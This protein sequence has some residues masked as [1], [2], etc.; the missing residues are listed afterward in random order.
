MTELN[1]VGIINTDKFYMYYCYDSPFFDVLRK[2]I[3]YSR[4]CRYGIDNNTINQFKCSLHHYEIMK[5]SYALGYNR[6]LILE[7]DIVFL[8]DL[9]LYQKILQYIPTTDLVLFDKFIC[10]YDE[11]NNHL[12][13]DQKINDYYMSFN[14]VSLLSSACYSVNRNAM[15]HITLSQEKEFE[16]CDH[17]WNLNNEYISKITKS[18]SI[19]NL[20]IQKN[21]TDHNCQ[22]FNEKL[23]YKFAHVNI[24]DYI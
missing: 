15:K 11:F 10:S 13:C 8:K 22:S 1:R 5:M 16:A 23:A 3:S 18:Y 19:K 6:I 20:G 7:D 9:E 24:N 12:I 2:N 17:V 14:H 4:S 21:Y